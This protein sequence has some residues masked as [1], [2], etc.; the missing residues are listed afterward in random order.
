MEALVDLLPGIGG[1]VGVLAAAFVAARKSKPEAG[2]LSAETDLI[3]VETLSK[4]VDSLQDELTRSQA[5]GQRIKAEKEAE[6]VALKEQH[7]RELETLRKECERLRGQILQM[8]QKLNFN[9]G[10]S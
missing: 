2:K 10:T 7:R 5:W 3:K 9:E 8:E 4:V 6:I 1:L